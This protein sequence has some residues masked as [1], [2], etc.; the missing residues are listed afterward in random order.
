MESIAPEELSQELR[1]LPIGSRKTL[2]EWGNLM[3]AGIAGGNKDDQAQG[4]GVLRIYTPQPHFDSKR[5]LLLL[6]R[7][8][9]TLKQARKLAE[10][11]NDVTGKKVMLVMNDGEYLS[12][13]DRT[14]RNW[15]RELEWHTVIQIYCDAPALA[16]VLKE[17][18]EGPKMPLLI[19]D[20]R[21]GVYFSSN[22]DKC[23]DV[24]GIRKTLIL[25][26]FSGDKKATLKI[27][28]T[29][30]GNNETI[31]MTAIKEINKHFCKKLFG[32]SPGKKDRLIIHNTTGGYLLN[33]EKYRIERKP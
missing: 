6:Q 25:M 30:Y 18:P 29:L 7:D 10:D 23:Y 22:P 15:N 26:L 1:N 31:T 8:P 4:V 24:S 33:T 3:S 28:K 2:R 32:R 16:N 5:S 20:D 19:I 12:T 11:I 13:S 17:L 27:L 21:K 14:D 9:G